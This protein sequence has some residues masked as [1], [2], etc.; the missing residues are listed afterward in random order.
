MLNSPIFHPTPCFNI[1]RHKLDINP[2]T[3][4]PETEKEI[5]SQVFANPEKELKKLSEA[6]P[7]DKLWFENDQVWM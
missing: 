4:E 6:Y 7:N 3:N 2:Y 1:C 5:V